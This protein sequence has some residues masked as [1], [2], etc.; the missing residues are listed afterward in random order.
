MTRLTSDFHCCVEF[1]NLVEELDFTRESGG[2]EESETSSLAGGWPGSSRVIRMT[3]K[4]PEL[5]K[6]RP[7]YRPPVAKSAVKQQKLYKLMLSSGEPQKGGPS[8]TAGAEKR[9][10][11]GRRGVKPP[12]HLRRRAGRLRRSGLALRVRW[13]PAEKPL[14]CPAEQDY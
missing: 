7:G 6:S 8:G 4:H 3:L 5:L 14:A 2:L 12:R 11:A 1:S 13:Q 10:Q 9:P